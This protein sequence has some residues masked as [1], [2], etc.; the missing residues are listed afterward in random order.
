M[1]AVT[2]SVLVSVYVSVRPGITEQ[3]SRRHNPLQHNHR[4]NPLLGFFGFL[5]NG[6]DPAEPGDLPPRDLAC[7][8]P[9]ALLLMSLTGGELWGSA[10]ELSSTLRQRAL[11]H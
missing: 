7:F 9:E 8:A 3:A 10:H 4:G 1:S 2:I 11:P 6:S 5:Q